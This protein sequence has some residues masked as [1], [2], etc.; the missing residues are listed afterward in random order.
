MN[1]KLHRRPNAF[2]LV[3]LL[4]VLTIISIMAALIINAFSN[5]SKD[6]RDV[7]ARQQQAVLKSALDNAISQVMAEGR[8]VGET[9]RFYNYKNGVSGTQR[10]MLERLTI[11]QPY[12]DEDTYTH[13]IAH[14]TASQI[15]SA[16]MVKTNQFI[17]FEFWATPTATVQNT[18]PKV[19]LSSGS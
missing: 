4:M 12:L 10:T 17:E 7:I 15:K 9:R 8:T 6:T 2:S 13:L 11:L 19:K 3:E 18:Y 14:S 5:A 1:T 16:A